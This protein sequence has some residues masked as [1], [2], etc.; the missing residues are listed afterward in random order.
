MYLGDTSKAARILFGPTPGWQS[1]AL[2][3]LY[4]QRR[5]EEGSLIFA[6]PVP[7]RQRESVYRLSEGA[8]E[9]GRQKT[10]GRERERTSVRAK[11]RE[12]DSS[13]VSR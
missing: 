11:E 10:L 5:L 9:G 1:V 2:M 7:V 6:S 13:E 8:G 3:A 12:R 4:S